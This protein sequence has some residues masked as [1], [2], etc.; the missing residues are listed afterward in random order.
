MGSGIALAAL[1]AHQPV[2]MV[3]VSEAVLERGLAYLRHHLERKGQLEALGDLQTSSALDALGACDMVIEAVPEDLELKRR[4]FGDLQAKCRADCVLATNTST[5]SVTAVAAAL[6]EPA[7][8][9]GMHFFNPAAVMPLV[10]V[11]RAGQ[12]SDSTIEGTVDLARRLGKTPVVVAD[13]PG[14]IVNRIARPFY[15]EA[16]KLL[17]EGAADVQTVD[18]ILHHGAGFRM[19]PFRLMDLIG[20][21]VN[22]AAMTSMYEQTYG[23]PRYRPHPI[24]R[25]KVRQGSLGR[26]TG[27]GFYDYGEGHQAEPPTFPKVSR[28]VGPVFM[29][30]GSWAPGVEDLLRTIGVMAES[31]QTAQAGLVPAGRQEALPEV[32]REMDRD[33]PAT[34]PLF[35]QAADV[36]MHEASQWVGRPDRL[37]GFDGLFL[38]SGQ[39]AVLTKGPHTTPEARNQ[40][41][42]LMRTLGKLPL[43]VDDPPGMVSP[44]IVAMLVNEAAFAVGEDVA[45]EATLDVAMELGVNYPHGPIKWGRALGFD[46]ILTVLEHLQREFGEDRYRPAPWLRGQVRAHASK[47]KGG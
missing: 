13:S 21:D 6:D 38:A 17:G 16:L 15:G 7:R 28:A 25:Q 18:W 39:V 4:V 19:G 12:T 29:S 2:V 47:T 27:S 41:D 36:T 45:P 14:F 11:I 9:V 34:V 8:T 20:I 26:K 43:W 31:A 22:L 32:L 46:R 3:D 24:Q 42:A 23:E 5:L 1:Y 37:I 10:E 35:C 44:R 33:L 30:K 40:A